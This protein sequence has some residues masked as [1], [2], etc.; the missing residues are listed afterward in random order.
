M[1]ANEPQPPQNE[2][3]QPEA[4]VLVFV[5]QAV[6]EFAAV[7]VARGDRTAFFATAPVARVDFFADALTILRWRFFAAGAFA[8]ISV[9]AGSGDARKCAGEREP[10]VRGDVHAAAL[11]DEDAAVVI[12]IR[13]DDLAEIAQVDDAIGRVEKRIAFDH[14]AVLA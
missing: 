7:D 12:A 10:R 8:K 1:P 13:G 14:A 6:Q 3:G 9:L 5:P 2:F 11:E 4:C